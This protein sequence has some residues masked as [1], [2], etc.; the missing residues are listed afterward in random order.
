[1][2]PNEVITII[3]SLI[4]AITGIGALVRG[5]ILQTEEKKQKEQEERE[6][7][8]RND[9]QRRQLEEEITIKV[10][11]RA[12]NQ[13][14]E[15]QRQLD[16]ALKDHSATKLENQ[17]RT[18]ELQKKLDL[19]IAEIGTLRAQVEQ[20]KALNAQWDTDWEKAMSVIRQLQNYIVVLIA[21]IKDLHGIPSPMP[22]IPEMTEI[23]QLQLKK[24]SSWDFGEARI[25]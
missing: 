4:G 3:G 13:I 18:D 5:I 2:T 8:K 11:A 22:D 1:M 12:Q 15:L 10:L 23:T 16:I 14:D 25:A 19:A 20:L 24:N 7:E 6:R 21:Q 17:K 9:I